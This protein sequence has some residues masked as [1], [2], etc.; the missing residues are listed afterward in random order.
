MS[1][2][3]MVSGQERLPTYL[4]MK[5]TE[6]EDF[7]VLLLIQELSQ[8]RRRWRWF[9]KRQRRGRNEWLFQKTLE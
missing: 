4:E 7:D 3:E 8:T 1:K 9:R 5:K 2:R 6:K